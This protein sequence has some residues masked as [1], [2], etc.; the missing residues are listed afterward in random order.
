MGDPLGFKTFQQYCSYKAHFNSSYNRKTHKGAVT[1]SPE[2]FLKRPDR[3]FFEIIEQKYTA[4]QRSQ[5]FLANSIY[6]KHIWIGELLTE[7]CVA[8]W[9]KW[10]GRISR[11]E[12]QFSEDIKNAVGEIA[13]RKGITKKEAL[14]FILK[15]PDNKHPYI[16]LFVWGGMLAIET[17]LILSKVMGLFEIYKPHLTDDR[18]WAD[19]EHKVSKY[20]HFLGGSI[21]KQH[22]KK[23]IKEI[24]EEQQ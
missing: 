5:M 1:A 3:L 15:K 12:Y 13:R 14:K 9:Q 19:F 22:Y 20:E 10:V 11:L 24:I 23:L 6:N 7:E 17:Y 21:K 2:S 18:L 4:A 16:L 8:V